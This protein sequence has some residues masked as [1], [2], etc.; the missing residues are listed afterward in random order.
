MNYFFI[1]PSLLVTVGS[2]SYAFRKRNQNVFL[3]RKYSPIKDID[4]YIK[5]QKQ[6]LKKK[7]W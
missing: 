2:I 6:A 1:I 3:K 7:N 4:L 5:D